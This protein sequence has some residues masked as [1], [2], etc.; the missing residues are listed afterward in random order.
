MLF[1]KLTILHSNF[2]YKI[3]KKIKLN[4][5]IFYHHFMSIIISAK[6]NFIFEIIFFDV[7]N[8]LKKF[9]ACICQVIYEKIIYNNSI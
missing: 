7:F 2:F 1:Y 9:I 5:N 3:K 4:F 8:L 6:A